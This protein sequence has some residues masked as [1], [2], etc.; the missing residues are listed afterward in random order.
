[1]LRPAPMGMISSCA[2][3]RSRKAETLRGSVHE[4][5]VW[6]LPDAQTENETCSWKTLDFLAIVCAAQITILNIASQ[7]LPARPSPCSGGNFRH[8]RPSSAYQ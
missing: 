4:S 1:M 5:P 8:R 2:R 3:D 7:L 6:P